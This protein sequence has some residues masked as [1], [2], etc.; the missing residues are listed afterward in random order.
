MAKEW[1]SWN[2]HQSFIPRLRSAAKNVIDARW[3]HKWKVVDGKKIIKSRL[4]VRGFKDVQ[5]QHVTTSA[6]TASRWG[7][8]MVVSAAVQHGWEISIADVSTAF[9]QGMS[10]E[11][12][13]KFTGEEIREVCFNPPKGSWMFLSAFPCIDERSVWT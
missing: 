11:E 4:C 12:L 3:V 9:L 8:I 6:S 10:F 5:G 7:Q 13:A 1:A 2:D